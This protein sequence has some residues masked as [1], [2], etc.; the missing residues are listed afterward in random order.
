MIK[1]RLVLGLL[2]S[3][4]ANTY[5]AEPPQ[6]DASRGQVASSACQGC[7]GPDGNSFSPDWPNLASQNANY[8]SKQIHDFQ[9][10]ARKDPTMSSMVVGLAERDIADIVAYFSSQTVKGDATSQS[11]AGQ[12][13]YMGGNRY[14]HVPACA[15]CHGPHGVGNG[16]GAIPHLAGQKAGYLGKT[17]RDFKSG[18][19]SN[20]RNQIMRDIAG[21]LTEKEITALAQFLAGMGATAE[22]SAQ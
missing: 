13:L 19:R 10:G 20:D 7:H 14:T 5:A 8:L 2:I 16:P 6:G 12:K 18:T 3:I 1:S 22:A 4:T 9:S 21:K 11:A 15:G 17:M